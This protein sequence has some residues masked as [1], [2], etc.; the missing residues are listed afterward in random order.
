K[1]VMW[2]RM[3][4]MEWALEA[5]LEGGRDLLFEWLIIDPRTKTNEQAE[6]AIDAILSM[7]ENEEMRKHFS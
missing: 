6:A 2:P 4:R 3:M 1:H 5:F 7:P